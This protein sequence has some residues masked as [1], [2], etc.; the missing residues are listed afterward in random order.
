MF[1]N[2]QFRDCVHRGVTGP[3]EQSVLAAVRGDHC[4]PAAAPLEAANLFYGVAQVLGEGRF[5][6]IWDAFQKSAPKV[7]PLNFADFLGGQPQARKIPAL[8]DLA[9]FDLAFG[10]AA[11]PGPMPSVGACCLPEV[12]LREH[13][14]LMLRFQPGW[15]YLQL[16]WPVHQLLPGPASED[17]LWALED[18]SVC[19]CLAPSGMGVNISELEP[20]NYALQS[21][22]RNGQR[23]GE[24][25]AAARAIDSALDPYPIVAGLVEAGAIIDVILHPAPTPRFNAL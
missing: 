16:N 6:E 7:N 12:V 3:T 13:S 19:L 2:I 15:R 11:Q 10:L 25:I 20:A 1:K 22:L 14:D 9:R 17:I 21:A 23:L 24:V 4:T 8:V 18:E 5:R